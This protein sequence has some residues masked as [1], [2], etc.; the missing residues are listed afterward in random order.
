MVSFLVLSW[1]FV[2]FTMLKNGIQLETLFSFSKLMESTHEQA[3]DH[4]SGGDSGGLFEQILGSFIYISPLCCGYT[5]PYV[6]NKR[7]RI[8]CFSSF[9][10][11]ILCMLLLSTKLA[12]VTGI[13][14]FF[15]GYYVAYISKMKCEMH[16]RARTLLILGVAGVGFLGLIYLSFVLRIGENDDSIRQIIINKIGVYAVGH[17]QG[18]DTWFDRSD[19]DTMGLGIYTFR[20]ISSKL[21]L[22]TKEQGVYSMMAGSCTNVYTPFRDLI[23]DWG[24]YA[25]MVWILGSSIICSI[26]YHTILSNGAKT[27][28]SQ[29]VLVT[30][31]FGFL[32]FI[33][34]WVY[35][36][37]FFV[38]LIF[39]WFLASCKLKKQS[40]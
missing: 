11:A 8:V 23:E 1:G 15:L 25:S 30:N 22:L 33:S 37:Y 17:I 13:I 19:H 12:F 5:L 3:V 21:G 28:I 29:F 31:M 20:A 18:F 32:Y 27:R 26:C 34:P 38:F 16:I 9:L 2:V 24:P 6:V 4:Y 36:T 40:F 14:L 39:G 10:P 35:T 7:Q